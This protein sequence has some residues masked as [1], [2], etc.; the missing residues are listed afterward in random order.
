MLGLVVF[1]R[2]DG[3]FTDCLSLFNQ[4]H[5]PISHLLNLLFQ[6]ILYGQNKTNLTAP[7]LYQTRIECAH[8]LRVRGIISPLFYYVSIGL[9]N[10]SDNAVFYVLHCIPFNNR[11]TVAVA[12]NKYRLQHGISLIIPFISPRS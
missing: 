3:Q 9:L 5:M 11:P 10:Y 4:S 7:L 1:D 6:F 12:D 8:Y 2:Y